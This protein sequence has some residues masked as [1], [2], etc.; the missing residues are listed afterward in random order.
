M[1]RPPGVGLGKS[2]N[3]AGAQHMLLLARQNQHAKA[4][5][6]LKNFVLLTFQTR[7]AEESRIAGE[8]RMQQQPTLSRQPAVILQGGHAQDL[9]DATHLSA[10]LPHL[11]HAQTG[12]RCAQSGSPQ[13]Q[14]YAPADWPTAP[15]CAHGPCTEAATIAGQSIDFNNGSRP[16]HALATLVWILSAA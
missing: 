12:R 6:L 2:F 1:P 3:V 16:D 4:A 8:A 9:K 15:A 14:E 13:R 10:L 11:G 5:K 7:P